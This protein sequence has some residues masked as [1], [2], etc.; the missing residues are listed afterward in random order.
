M[1]QQ[2][3]ILS[4]SERLKEPLPA[5]DAQKMM[6]PVSSNRYLQ[7]PDNARQAGVMILLSGPH[8][9]LKITYIKRTSRYPEDPHNGQISFAGGGREDQDNDLKDTAIRECLE[10]IGISSI[11]YEIIGAMSPIYV[12]V[13]N[14]Y[15]QPYVAYAEGH[16]SYV[17]QE[18][19]VDQVIE[20]PLRTMM[21][22][23]I[24]QH[25]DYNIR[26]SVIKNMPYYNL[27]PHILWGATAMITAELLTIIEE[28]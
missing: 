28:I 14:Y 23:D 17:L 10:E 8:D 15:V 24:I 27:D 13:S 21:Q 2:K 1:M 12:Y 6:S 5:W 26:G 16:L 3:I 9:D 18:T 4:L 20:V 25:M 11:T 19:E 7:Y 22:N